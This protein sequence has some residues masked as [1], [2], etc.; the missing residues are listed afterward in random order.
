MH[1]RAGAAHAA[2]ET[3]TA[4]TAARLVSRPRWPVPTDCQQPC[5]RAAQPPAPAPPTLPLPRPCCRL[6]CD[7]HLQKA[8]KEATGQ[9]AGIAKKAGFGSG[10]E[11]S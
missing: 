1:W 6:C 9:L 7:V 2:A 10:A 8:G 11:G 4:P 5:L 3:A